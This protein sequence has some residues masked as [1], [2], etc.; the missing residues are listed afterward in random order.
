MEILDQIKQMYPDQKYV[1]RTAD[2]EYHLT[3]E[4]AKAQAMHLESS[5]IDRIT[6]KTRKTISV[7]S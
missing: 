1:Y 2:Q 7:Q 4:G 3:L 6:C 5:S